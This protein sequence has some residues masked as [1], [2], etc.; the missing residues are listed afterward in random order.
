V[1]RSS[2]NVRKRGYLDR[3]LGLMFVLRQLMNTYILLRFRKNFIMQGDRTDIQILIVEDEILIAEYIKRCLEK[4]DIVFLLLPVLEKKL[5]KKLQ[6]FL[7][8]SDNGYGLKAIWMGCKL[9]K[10]FGIPPNSSSVFYW[11]CR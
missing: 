4:I 7:K 11:L 1:F 3:D 5:L 8:I 6:R 9:P 10:P 2:E